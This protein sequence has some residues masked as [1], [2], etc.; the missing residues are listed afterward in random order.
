MRPLRQ[1]TPGST[2]GCHAES[3]S[4]LVSRTTVPEALASFFL[5]RPQPVHQA[6]VFTAVSQVLPASTVALLGAGCWAGLGKILSS[7]S[8][9]ILVHIPWI[10][11]DSR[12]ATYFTKRVQRACEGLWCQEKQ[13]GLNLWTM[14]LVPA[15]LGLCFC[16]FLLVSLQHFL[17]GI[18]SN[19]ST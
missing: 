13:C 7:K 6:S 3:R 8:S 4:P 19:F 10:D 9:D 5:V 12:K 16:F 15:E 1:S 14:M 11:N 2:S 17:F 18:L